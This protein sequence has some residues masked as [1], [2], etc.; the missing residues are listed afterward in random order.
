[1]PLDEYDHTMFEDR[2]SRIANALE[3]IADVLETLDEEIIQELPNS[4]YAIRT[5]RV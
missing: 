2:L 5:T 4:T 1:M 3:R